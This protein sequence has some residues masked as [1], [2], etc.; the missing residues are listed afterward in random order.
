M[1]I[2]YKAWWAIKKLNIDLSR[3]GVKRFLDLDELE[4]YEMMPT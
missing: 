1:E 4:D 2:K 3:V